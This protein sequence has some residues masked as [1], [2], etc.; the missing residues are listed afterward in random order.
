MHG[1]R[2][3]SHKHVPR[4]CDTDQNDSRWYFSDIF[5]YSLDRSCCENTI[6]FLLFVFFLININWFEFTFKVS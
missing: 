3:N 6:S 2:T 1:C 4:L 5:S